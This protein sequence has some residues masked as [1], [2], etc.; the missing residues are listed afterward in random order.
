VHCDWGALKIG[1]ITYAKAKL[2]RQLEFPEA[3]FPDAFVLTPGIIR[4]S[5]RSIFFE[6]L[7]RSLVA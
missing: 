2:G 4:I 1:E 6:D 5:L 3:V 7:I